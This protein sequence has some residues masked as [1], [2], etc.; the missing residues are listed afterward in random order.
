MKPLV[1]ATNNLHKLQEI[2]HILGHIFTVKSLNDIDCKDKIPETKHTLKDN[3][4]E[5][6]SYVYEKYNINCFADDTGLEIESLG[7]APGVYSAR[8]AGV[9]ASFEDNIKKTLKLMAGKSNRRAVF[10]TFI[11]LAYN[12]VFHTFE[13][14]VSGT[15]T[16]QKSGS[17]GFGYDPIFLPDGYDKTFAEM[18]QEEKNAISHRAIAI[19]KLVKFL[20]QDI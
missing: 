20:S 18:N 8:F 9:D 5:K 7:G 1:F 12:N 3:A 15:I 6:A 19:E 17:N 11:A 10:K 4:L 16:L 2:R 14:A 13:G